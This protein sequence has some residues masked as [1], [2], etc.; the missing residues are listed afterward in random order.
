MTGAGSTGCLRRLVPIL[1]RAQ[2]AFLADPRPALDRIVRSVAAFRAG[3]AYDRATAEYGACQLA[4]LGLVSNP[5]DGI[6]GSVDPTKVQRMLAI[7]GPV[8]TA[9]RT[10]P[11]AGITAADL[12]TTDYLDHA[13]SLPARPA[14]RGI[15]CT[16]T[17]TD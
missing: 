1:Q 10:P 16:P 14:L 6:A 7:T 9:T 5:I 17:P 12:V 13:V 4:A 2:V 8:L 15:H 3:F 11:R